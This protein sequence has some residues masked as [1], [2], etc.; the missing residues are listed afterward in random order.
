[1]NEVNRNDGRTVLFVSHNI[2][3]IQRL[4]GIGI[5]LNM[6][7]VLMADK[8][9]NV[10]TRY[11]ELTGFSE[12]EFRPNREK[13]K[14]FV[15]E[16]RLLNKDQLPVKIYSGDDCF[17]E[18]VVHSNFDISNVNIGFGIDD[19]TGTRIFTLYTKY[20]GKSYDVKKGRNVIKCFVPGLKLKPD[21]YNILISVANEFEHFDYNE[22]GTSIEICLPMNKY[23]MY[24]DNSQGS[25]IIDQQWD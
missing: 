18:I 4:C 22:N 25:L 19:R 12:L 9:A 7:S 1:M 13:L 3:A 23:D 16:F 8:I 10:V 2:Q 21:N 24:P 20:F 14:M 15:A 17:F 6:G 5:L 11:S